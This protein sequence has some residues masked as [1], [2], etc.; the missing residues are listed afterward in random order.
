MP[1]SYTTIKLFIA[2]LTIIGSYTQVIAQEKED[3]PALKT[4][5]ADENYEY[6][7][8]ETKNPYKK[9]FADPLKH[10]NL[11]KDKS[12]YLTLGGQY[13]PRIEHFTNKDWTTEDETFYSQRLNL[14]ANLNFGKYLRF[15]GE[16]YHGYTSNEEQVPESDV[17]DWHQGFIELKFP[18]G[19]DAELSFRFGR[20]EM[21]LGASRLVGNREGP[22]MRRTFDLGAIKYKK[23]NTNI[24]AFYGKEVSTEFDAFDNTFNLFDNDATDPELWGIGTQ[25]PIKNLNGTNELYYLGFRSKAAGFSNVFG[26]EVRHSIGLRRFGTKGKKITYNTEVIYQ[27]GD[28]DD[29]T[30]SAF[31]IETDWK[32]I[33]INSKW[34]TTI[35][36]KL[37]WS[38]GDKEA[39]DDKIQTF[40]PL[41]VNPAIY[42]LAGV[43]TPANL[44]SFHPNV[45]VFP[46][47]GFSIYIDYAIFYR[48]SKNDGL[49]TP[50]RFQIR[51]ANGLSEKH[52][53]DA[54]GMQLTYELNRNISFDLRSTYFIPGKFIKASGDSKATFY[55]APTVSFK[56]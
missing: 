39:E 11:N 32:Y 52:I 36:I 1:R 7:E 44:T 56:F 12:I 5:R 25:F 46:A 17:I 23:G 47:E 34:R 38:T 54:V 13:R 22:N 49:Y 37:D 42:S 20:Q 28:L 3:P 29:A 21:A 45:T 43:N 18:S 31:N 48:T 8:D 10:I 15:F 19:E 27:F 41:F 35:G 53:G 4:N 16:L 51:E 6:L 24:K 9:G 30:I 14:H 55:I 50:P 40:N 26:E 2:F 33:F